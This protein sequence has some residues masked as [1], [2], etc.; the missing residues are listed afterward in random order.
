MYQFEPMPSNVPADLQFHIL[1]AQA[2]LWTEWVP[3][4]KHAEY[5]IFPRECALAE[6]TWSPKS[7]RDFDDFSRRMQTECQRF[8]VLGINYR[9]ITPNSSTTTTAQ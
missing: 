6:D 5:M 3:N 8:D 4:L 1:G 7:S 9:H 2:N